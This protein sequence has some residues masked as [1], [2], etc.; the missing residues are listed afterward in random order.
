MEEDTVDPIGL[1]VPL[2]EVYPSFT[3]RYFE[4]KYLIDPLGRIGEDHC[5]LVHSNRICILTLAPTHPILASKKGISNINFKIAN[6][7]RLENTV[8]GKRKR[9]AQGLDPMSVLCIIECEDGRS[10]SL[11]SCVYG[12]LI[13]INE[14]LVAN[15]QL[16]LEKPKSD[17]YVAIILPNIRV[18]E[19]NKAELLSEEEYLGAVANRKLSTEVQPANDVEVKTDIK[20]EVE[21]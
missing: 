21:M 6:K 10:Y 11:R 9:G 7:N 20:P 12:K 1:D 2:M 18:S 4:P 16:L 14:N 13:E 19:K 17:G 8:Q 15:P 5:V 3:E